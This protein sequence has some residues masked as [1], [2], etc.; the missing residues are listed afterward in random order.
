MSRPAAEG[1]KI[2]AGGV[3]SVKSEAFAGDAAFGSTRVQPSVVIPAKAAIHAA[4]DLG[5]RSR[6]SRLN[7]S[8]VSARDDGEGGRGGRTSGRRCRSALSSHPRSTTTLRRS[9]SSAV[10]PAEAGI[11]T[12]W[13]QRLGSVQA[14]PAGVSRPRL[15]SRAMRCRSRD[16]LLK[17]AKASSGRG[18]R[19]ACHRARPPQ[20]VRL[21]RKRVS[22]R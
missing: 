18:E 17:R 22:W 13:P 6:Q 3:G 12:Q 5:V 2:R 14:F 15:G 21:K 8:R 16:E 19:H 10:I 9:K 20:P 11:Q 4:E 7:G 1:K